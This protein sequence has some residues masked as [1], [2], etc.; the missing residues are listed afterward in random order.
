MATIINLKIP[1]R[2]IVR[3]SGLLPMMYTL[4]ELASALDMPYN[5]LRGWLSTG[6]PHERDENG[7]IWTN[8]ELFPPW[9]RDQRKEKTHRELASDEGFCMSCKQARRIE[10]PKIF[11][12]KGK[13]KQIRGSC[14]VC[15]HTI[16][17][18][19]KDD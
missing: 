3:A 13:I 19:I 2:V 4:K 18:G 1:H 6:L 14:P 16:Y 5:T 7:R 10:N 15:H 8:G 12:I 17:R 11:H 9:V